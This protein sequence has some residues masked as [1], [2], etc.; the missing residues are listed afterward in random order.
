MEEI[1]DGDTM[2]MIELTHTERIP[3]NQ[4]YSPAA[5]NPCGA[6]C[7]LFGLVCRNCRGRHS[8]TTRSDTKSQK[9]ALRNAVTQAAL[10]IVELPTIFWWIFWIQTLSSF[11]YFSTA[12]QL[13]T[14]IVDDLHHPASEASW[15]YA[16]YGIISGVWS[17]VAGLVVDHTGPIAV[18]IASSLFVFAGRVMLVLCKLV[19][20]SSWTI[21]VAM[22]VFAALGDGSISVTYRSLVTHIFVEHPRKRKIVFAL[23]YASINIGAMCAGMT[24]ELMKYSALRI[25]VTTEERVIG[26]NH[27]LFAFLSIV[28]LINVGLVLAASRQGRALLEFMKQKEVE[29]SLRKQSHLASSSSSDSSLSDTDSGE[30]GS[31]T[32]IKAA[33]IDAVIAKRRPACLDILAIFKSAPIY[34]FILL[35]FFCIGVRSIFRYMDT[36]MPLVLRRV[37]G[38]DVPFGSLYAI[39]PILLIFLAPIV[40]TLISKL[41][42]MRWIMVGMW[43]SAFAPLWMTLATPH[44]WGLLGVILFAVTFAIGEAFWSPR[45]DDYA[46]EVAKPQQIGTFM[47]TVVPVGFLAKVFVGFITNWLFD[48]HC[49]A[50]HETCDMASIWGYVAGIS[51]VLSPLMVTLFYDIIYD[52]NVRRK[53]NKRAI[54]RAVLHLNPLSIHNAHTDTDDD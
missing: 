11:V 41:S 26:S 31:D 42:P 21:W 3:V 40:Q 29:R 27:L 8:K 16:S 12:M 2:Q 15:V 9:G 53:W 35:N 22:C 25:D 10:I 52:P 13:T 39:D 46:A 6:W 33:V 48:R 17:F 24:V 45:L 49:S 30:Y 20:P 14:F 32:E 19:L 43:L 28:A 34:R 50:T 51:A 38:P 23:L 7:C 18:M 5:H 36:L 4:P 1:E 37:Y 54:E 47:A 44:T